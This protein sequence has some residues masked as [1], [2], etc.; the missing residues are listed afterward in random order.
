MLPAFTSLLVVPDMSEGDD[1]GRLRLVVALFRGNIV[2][3]AGFLI[4]GRLVDGP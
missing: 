2:G 4:V 1:V 3:I